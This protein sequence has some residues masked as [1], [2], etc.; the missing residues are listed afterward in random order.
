MP[1]FC[2]QVF[3]ATNQFVIREASDGEIKSRFPYT[4]EGYRSA[5]RFLAVWEWFGE[6]RERVR[7]KPPAE[8]PCRFLLQPIEDIAC[9]LDADEERE[10]VYR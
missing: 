8:Q 3:A 9:Q 5:E 4:A 10:A 7:N 6:M 2:I 1:H